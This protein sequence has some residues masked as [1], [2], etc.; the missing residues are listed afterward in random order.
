MDALTWG[1][2]FLTG[3]ERIDDEH[4]RLFELVSAFGALV[5]REAGVPRAELE[6]LLDEV[7][8][9]ARTHFIDEEAVMQEAG[10]DER[11]ASAHRRQHARFLLDVGA[12]RGPDFLSASGAA[13]ALLRFLL[14]W[15]A[16]HILGADMQLARQI[17]RIRKGQSPAEAWEAEAHEDQA[18]GLLLMDAL[19]EVLGVVTRRNEELARTVAELRFMQAHLVEQE[20]LATV[21]VLASG[22]AHELNNPL[23]FVTANVASLGDHLSAM[24]SVIDS[25]LSV[26][27]ALPEAQRLLFERA[28]DQADLPFVRTDLAQLVD[29]TRIGLQRLQDI[30]KSLR[31]FA[32]VHST[33]TIEVD[34][35]N[36]VETTVRLIPSRLREGVRFVTHHA[37]APPVC[38]RVTQVNHAI[39]NLLLN[40]T[41]AV[42]DTGRPGLV[43]VRTGPERHG[44]FVEVQDEGIGIPEELRSRIFEPFFTTRAAGH[45]AGLGLANARA[46]AVSHGGSL[47]VESAPGQ[48]SVFHL[49][50]PTEPDPGAAS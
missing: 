28:R 50:L 30:V 46:C 15:L 24:W 16:S 9:Y 23:A 32:G 43:T 20:K 44:V 13:R 31:E 39:L 4:R 33:T 17:E 2:R 25:A 11:F 47:T 45:G 19:D 48:G 6:K 5:A 3:L 38:C 14:N 34:L 40:A 42:R 8:G 41:Q 49:W 10:V 18:P 37:P 7:A 26:A 36:C 12:M 21:G 22:V 35:R 27:P 1:D 29:E